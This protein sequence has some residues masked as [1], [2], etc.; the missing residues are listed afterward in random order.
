MNVEFSGFSDRGKIR[1]ANEDSFVIVP[2]LG[3]F[4]VADGMGGHNAGE[5]ASKMAT[6]IL[7]DYLARAVSGGDVTLGGNDSTYSQSANRLASGIRLAN[8]V[9]YE[10]ALTNPAWRSMGTTI[11]A[12]KFDETNGMSIAHVGDSRAYL[13]RGGRLIPLTEDHSMVAEQVR[14]ELISLEEAEISPQRNILTRAIG[15]DSELEVDLCDLTLVPKDRIL[16]C[17]DGLTTMVSEKAISEIIRGGSNPDTVCR[18]LVEEA[19][20]NGGRDNVTAVLI[21]VHGGLLSRFAHMFNW[22]R[23]H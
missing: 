2:E 6:D 21:A 3:L 20:R 14:L 17:S 18:Q 22:A 16:L 13:M 10:S 1:E 9:I 23:R 19:N 5:V 12:V 15:I 7:R 4:A 11:V 8:R